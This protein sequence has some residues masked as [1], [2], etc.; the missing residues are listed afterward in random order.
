MHPATYDAMYD[1]SVILLHQ[2]ELPEAELLLRKNLIGRQQMLPQNHPNT[3]NT[4]HQLG[5]L[6]CKQIGWKHSP[7][8]DRRI[9]ETEKL[10]L[11]C[12][13]GRKVSL[14]R[15]H[16][17]TID[18]CLCYAEFLKQQNRLMESDQYYTMV[19]LYYRSHFH[20][21]DARVADVIYTLGCINQLR[22][23]FTEAAEYFHQSYSI[24][25]IVYKDSTME[26]ER[27]IVQD[28]LSLYNNC[29]LRQ[30]I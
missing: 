6:V 29:K 5:K 7:E 26:S 21:H 1:L 9:K 14:G 15:D 28:S 13:E 11:L 3:L 20:M 19:L 30:S 10:F 25:S 4:M 16:P 23:R 27:E 24:Y 17:D 18:T 2:D 12:I 22:H 8:L